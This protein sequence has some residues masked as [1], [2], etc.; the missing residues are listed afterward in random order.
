[1][2]WSSTVSGGSGTAR[3]SPAGGTINAGATATVTVT[4]SGSAVGRQVTINP[5]GTV[6]TIFIAL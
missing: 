5:G 1:M 6:L 2:T 3:L 4:A